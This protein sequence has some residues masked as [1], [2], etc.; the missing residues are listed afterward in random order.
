MKSFN[1]YLYR[2]KKLISPQ[3]SVY[4]WAHAHV[5]FL[6]LLG[7]FLFVVN[8]VIH[9]N[10]KALGSCTCVCKEKGEIEK[11]SVRET[12]I[13]FMWSTMM[14]A[15]GYTVRIKNNLYF[16]R[17]FQCNFGGRYVH[18]HQEESGERGLRWTA[19]CRCPCTAADFKFQLRSSV[20]LGKQSTP[21]EPQVVCL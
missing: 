6:F 13:Y 10:E 19:D 1:S 21:A 5:C 2:L 15:V 16:Q 8:S 7:F 11:I 20:T 12:V 3:Q 14:T 4:M 17:R 9:W 18:R